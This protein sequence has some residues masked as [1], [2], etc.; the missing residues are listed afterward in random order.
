MCSSSLNSTFSIFICE[1]HLKSYAGTHTRESTKNTIKRKKTAYE[2]R[3]N[4]VFCIRLPIFT[5]PCYTPRTIGR[6]YRIQRYKKKTIYVIFYSVRLKFLFYYIII[7]LFR[8]IFLSFLL[9]LY[10][11][12]VLSFHIFV[13]VTFVIR[14]SLHFLYT[15]SL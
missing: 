13:V 8:C 5:V 14:L 9:S 3:K 1:W 15:V 4:W 6:V 10:S 12:C 7:L 2:A 11:L